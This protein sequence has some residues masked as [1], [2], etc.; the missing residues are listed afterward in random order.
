M[1]L[2]SNDTGLLQARIDLAAL[3]RIAHAHQWNESVV[4]HMTFMVPGRSDQYLIIPYG[5]HWDEVKA[6]DFLIV[7]MEGK[8]VSG[9]GEAEVSAISL[10]GPMHRRLPQAR[11]V[12]HTHQPNLTA[13]TALRDQRLLMVHQDATLFHGIV[14]YVETYGDL[15]LD[16]TAGEMV[17]DAMNEAFVLLMANH[18]PMVVGHT[19]AQTFQTL[20]YLDRIAAVQLKAMS[21]GR[22]IQEIGDDLAAKMAPI[23]RDVYLGR[24]A[25]LHF[26]ARKRL[27][28]RE[29][30]DYAT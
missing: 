22:E 2:H 26:D 18:G 14:A 13:L 23:V 27:L 28:D 30:A 12:L 21:T 1:D 20:Y 10:H 29:G 8:I 15:P 16:G 6:S 17:A 11:C 25:Q 4:N 9:T 3:H 19:I 7:D 24:E 5:L